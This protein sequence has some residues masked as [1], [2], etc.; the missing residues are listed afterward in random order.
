[1]G[2]KDALMG[3]GVVVGNLGRQRK[4]E[5]M[6][7][8]DAWERLPPPILHLFALD[9]AERALGWVKDRR[10]PEVQVCIAGLESKRQWLAGR[11]G[12]AERKAKLEEVGRCE[13]ALWKIHDA[14]QEPTWA[15]TPPPLSDL[16]VSMWAAAAWYAAC[17]AKA[18]LKRSPLA[19]ASEASQAALDTAVSIWAFQAIQ[20]TLEGWA[21]S[22]DPGS[23]LLA[24]AFAKE[25]I[26]PLAR[27]AEEEWQEERLRRLWTD[28]LAHR[29]RLLALLSLRS[30]KIALSEEEEGKI[31]EAIL[32]V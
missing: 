12:E 26:T 9:C 13:I 28:L 25:T 4:E 21:P 31:L 22:E 8:K 32:F 19:A 18:A 15:S 16:G 24:S 1:M 27:K 29:S 5:K 14:A 20:R 2:G 10:Q 6:G 3:S 11:I 7:G 30:R 17:A 23:R